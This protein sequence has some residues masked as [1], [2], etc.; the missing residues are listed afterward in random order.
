MK[1]KIKKFDLVLINLN[2][3]IG[4]VVSVKRYDKNYIMWE[5][6]YCEVLIEE[7]VFLVPLSNLKR[8]RTRKLL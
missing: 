4:L 2:K 3:K 6:T 7:K 5:G 8:I 1:N